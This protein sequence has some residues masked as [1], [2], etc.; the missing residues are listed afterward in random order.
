MKIE[1]FI[2][3]ELIS[4]GINTISKLNIKDLAD[5]FDINV[6][7]WNCKSFLHFD[8]EHSIV[9]DINKNFLDQ[10]EEFL[11]ELGHYILFQ[12]HVK[13]IKS[14]REWRYIEGKV[15]YIVPFI[16]I[17][18]FALGEALAQNTIQEVSSLFH[19]STELAEKRIKLYKNKILKAIGF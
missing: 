5:A 3:N 17:P 7:Y 1:D 18:N 4:R 9:I 16:A 8:E 13:L 6:Y 19:V 12:N 2:N 11:H 10:Y 14:V 15:N